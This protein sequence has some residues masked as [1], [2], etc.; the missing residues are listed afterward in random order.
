MNLLYLIPLISALIG[1]FTNFIAVKMLFYP[2]QEWNLLLF[3]LQG[4]FPKRK[5]VLA[6]RLGKVVA[7]ELLSS[8]SIREHVANEETHDDLRDAVDKEVDSYLRNRR[9]RLGYRIFQTIF[10]DKL[11][12]QLKV[13]ILVE[14]E[15]MIPNL[16]HGMGEKIAQLDVEDVVSKQ[17]QG[18][19]SR[20]IEDMLKSILQR[21]LHFIELAGA[22]LGFFIGVLQVAIVLWQA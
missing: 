15:G 2:R 17:V 22:V 20:K 21:E 13:R 1:W 16:V 4:I 5:E 9:E 11:L 19:D 7:E 8:E 14:V 12:E 10:H 18:F 6:R 3:K